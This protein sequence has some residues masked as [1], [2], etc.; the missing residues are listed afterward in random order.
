M[1]RYDITSTSNP[2][3][4]RL[5]RLRE[6]RHRDEEG[7]FVVEGRTQLERA[8]AAG[9]LPEEVYLDGSLP[10]AGPGE[11]TTVDPDILAR[12]AYR[13]RSQGA[14]AVLPQFPVDLAGITLSERP[15]VLV[16]ES[17]EKPGNLGAMLRT[18]DAVGGDALI[19]V[20]QVVDP[21]N[22][23]VVRASLGALFGVPLAVTELETLQG[24]VA[25]HGLNVVAADP[26][27]ATPFWELDLSDPVAIV[28]GSEARGLTAGALALAAG[29]GSIPMLGRVDSLNS[30]V[31]LALLAYE[32]LRQRR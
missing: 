14:I 23:N 6:R 11:I 16:A 30:S 5:M 13:K 25:S 15:L 27:S 17:I 31:S 2:Q 21:F 22:P 12:A 28:V 3:I 10:Y 19:V 29:T 8:I 7:V 20:G 26:G 9:R 32:A 18:V 4:K 24:W 1:E